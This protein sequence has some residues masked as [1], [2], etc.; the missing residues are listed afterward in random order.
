M[1]KL[2]S[3]QIKKMFDAHV[4]VTGFSATGV[5]DTITTPLTTAVSSAGDLGVSVPLQV[6]TYNSGTQTEGI[7]TASGQNKVEIYDATTKQKLDDG[8]GNEVYGRVTES[9][10]AYT[11][12]YFSLIAGSETSFDIGS[13]TIDFEFPYRF[14]LHNLPVNALIAIQSRNTDE[15]AGGGAGRLVR[16]LLTV[17]STNTL[18][19][20]TYTPDES[21][22]VHLTVNGKGEDTLS[23]SGLTISGKTLTWNAGTIGYACKTT[24][25]VV[26]HYTTL[27]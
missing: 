15:D 24:F 10:G 20:L 17:T 7:V 13:T 11:L 1:S 3:S 14:E 6:S 25:R 5:S 12:S 21:S 4:R 8:Q 2:D 27:E 16:E 9:G 23:G 19:N 22:N 18:S 26:A